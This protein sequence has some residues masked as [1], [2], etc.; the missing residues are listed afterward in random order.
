MCRSTRST[1][2]RPPEAAMSGGWRSVLIASVAL[3]AAGA[4]AHA[5]GPMSPQDRAREAAAMVTAAGFQVR[6][7]QIVNPCGRPTQPR[8]TAVDLNGDGKP[9]AVIT[10]IDAACYGGTGEAF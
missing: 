3:A 6:G 2:A 5:Q 4:P 10:D 9:E 1:N 8:P 7:N